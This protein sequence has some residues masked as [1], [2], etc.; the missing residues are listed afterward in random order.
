VCVQV[1]VALKKAAPVVARP[2]RS[3][4]E[5][6]VESLRSARK[7]KRGRAAS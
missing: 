5:E 4:L 2:A 3:S 7:G 1:G 6:S